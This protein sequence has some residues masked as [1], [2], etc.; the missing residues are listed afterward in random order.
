MY[1]E[2]G[3]GAFETAGWVHMDIPLDFLEF[4]EMSM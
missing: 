2:R 1:R 4:Q 3:E